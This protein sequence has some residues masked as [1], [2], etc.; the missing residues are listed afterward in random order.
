VLVDVEV[1]APDV[2]VDDADVVE[3]APA[4]VVDV[5]AEVTLGTL[6]T[7]AVVVVSSLAICGAGAGWLWP[8]AA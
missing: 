8:R 5:V 7:G 3:V 4:V 1:E 2:L 6:A